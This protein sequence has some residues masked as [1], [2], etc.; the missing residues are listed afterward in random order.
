MGDNGR[1]H[2]MD[3]YWLY[4][5]GIHVPLIVR[6]PGI[7][8]PNT[9]SHGLVSG[10]DISAT[11]LSVCGISVPDYFQGIPFLGKNA[12]ERQYVYAARDRIDEAYDMVRSV[13]GQKFKYI[14]NFM[15]NRPYAQYRDF[16]RK[17]NPGYPLIK[18][19]ANGASDQLNKVQRKYTAKTKP[20]EELYDI[21]KDPEELNN[22]AYDQKFGEEIKKFRDL[23]K[24]WMQ[25]IDDKARFEETP[26]DIRGYEKWKDNIVFPTEEERYAP[27]TLDEF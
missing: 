22:L 9:V 6:W 23:L 3:E 26:R 13:R 27:E 19:M 7:I 18:S 4:D 11:I 25:D 1:D 8:P 15:P 14:R 16:L 24:K 20:E 10:V 5:G 21:T 17:V 12:Q 2:L